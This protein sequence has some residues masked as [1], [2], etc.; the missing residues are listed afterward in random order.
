MARHQNYLQGHAKRFVLGDNWAEP[1]TIDELA[2]DSKKVAEISSWLSSHRRKCGIL[3]LTGPTGG[4]KTTV[5]KCVGRSLG[6]EIREW[7]TP[8]DRDFQN[9]AESGVFQNQTEKFEDYL[10]SCSRYADLFVKSSTAA[11]LLLVEDYP[12]IFLLKPE[13]FHDLLG[14]YSMTA[15]APIIFICS[16]VADR[17]LNI[18]MELFPASIQMRLG[19]THV[20][21]NPVT[22]AKMLLAVKRMASYLQ[23]ISPGYKPPPSDVVNEICESAS[24]DVRYAMLTLQMKPQE[25]VAALFD[26]AGKKGPTRK[27]TN[28]QK[29]TQEEEVVSTCGKDDRVGILRAVGRIL[30]PKWQS[31][32]DKPQSSQVKRKR[33]VDDKHLDASVPGAEWIHNP[34]TIV[35]SYISS[36]G[37]LLLL[38]EENYLKTYSAIE[39]VSL[40][41]RCLS[42]ADIMMNGVGVEASNEICLDAFVRGVMVHNKIPN[43]AF[44]P[45]KGSR[46]HELTNTQQKVNALTETLFPLY[47]VSHTV[48]MSDVIPYMPFCCAEHLSNDQG[49]F[50]SHVTSMEPLKSF[51]ENFRSFKDS[52]KEQKS[53]KVT[54]FIDPKKQAVQQDDELHISEDESDDDN[55][56]GAKNLSMLV[57]AI[58]ADEEED[59]GAH[60]L[61]L[62]EEAIREDSQQEVD[63]AALLN[64]SDDDDLLLTQM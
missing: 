26:L 57:D 21:L 4:G 49:R 1:Y 38:V 50:A 42:D 59:E 63:Y 39:S 5:V 33:K 18:E 44:T 47:P 6:F 2:V 54:F 29:L 56:E 32:G 7:I 58:A 40:A 16:D 45:V 24:G 30:Y 17:N 10:Y 28:A 53:E 51:C 60:N 52:Q 46:Y 41:A 14:K 37:S 43:R 25:D 31:E 35:D 8:L 48:L 64:D 55:N 11:S 36:A 19:M 22:K 3:L 12:N 9:G 13:I 23:S 34:S 20:K 27:K 61:T 15:K 62:L